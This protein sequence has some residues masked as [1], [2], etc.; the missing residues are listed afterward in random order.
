[1]VEVVDSSEEDEIFDM[2]DPVGEMEDEPADDTD[3]GD[4]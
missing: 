4:S 2:T 1:M 3:L